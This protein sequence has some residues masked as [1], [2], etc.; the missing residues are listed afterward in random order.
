[1][2][3]YRARLNGNASLKPRSKA[4]REEPIAVLIKSWPGL[5]NLDVR[6][7]AKNEYL[8]WATDFAKTAAPSNYNNTVMGLI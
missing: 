1:L 8:N 5:E 4:Y 3:I 7:I 6:K 2:E